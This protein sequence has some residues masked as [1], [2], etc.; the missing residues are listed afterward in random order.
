VESGS[1]DGRDLLWRM[2]KNM[3]MACEE[4]LPDGSYLSTCI[5]PNGLAAQD[6]GIVL[7]WLIT[8]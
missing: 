7:R 5:L 1:F 3:R 6:N 4:R 8:V 2:K